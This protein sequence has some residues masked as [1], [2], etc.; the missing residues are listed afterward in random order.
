[1]GV[2]ETSLSPLSQANNENANKNAVR[3]KMIFFIK[4]LLIILKRLKSIVND[5][6][7]YELYASFIHLKY[8]AKLPLCQAFSSSAALDSVLFM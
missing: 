1:M 6:A 7:P 5:N 2:L 8:T 4:C 3:T